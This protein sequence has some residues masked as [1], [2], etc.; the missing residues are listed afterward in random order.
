MKDLLK[1]VIADQLALSWSESLTRREVPEALLKMEDIVVI[2]GIRRCG[3]STLLH[4][5]RSGYA[6]K[7]YYMNFDYE[8][9]LN[10]KV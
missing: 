7:D 5:I 10:F 8:R 2:S 9:L 1:T 6:E 3:K 4:Q